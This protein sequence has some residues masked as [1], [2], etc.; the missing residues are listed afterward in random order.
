[1]SH[2][3][4]RYLVEDGSRDEELQVLTLLPGTW[5]NVSSNGRVNV[6]GRGWKMIALPFADDHA[7]FRLFMKQYNECLTFKTVDDNVPNRG[8]SVANGGLA[9]ADQFVV[10]LDYQQQIRQFAQGN[11]FADPE[12]DTQSAAVADIH[13]EPGL[14]LRMK[15]EVTEGFDIA[16]LAT[17]PHG[18][19]VLALDRSADW[20]EGAPQIPATD[21]RPIGN[22]GKYG[23]TA[24]FAV[25][26]KACLTERSQMICSRKRSNRRQSCVTSHCHSIQNIWVAVWSIFHSLSTMPTRPA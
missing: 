26:S 23:R 17:I 22:Q 20:V 18:N 15:N 7:G 9:Q 24:T 25:C 11:R 13:H 5:A 4:Q 19:S 8:I 12:K 6:P 21:G 14:L 1:M 10:T 3:P 16:R 2:E